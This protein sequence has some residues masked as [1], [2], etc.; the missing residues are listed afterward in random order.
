MYG[1]GIRYRA[2]GFKSEE[3]AK[4]FQKQRGGVIYS[5]EKNRN[6]HQDAAV[7]NSFDPRKFPYSVNWQELSEMAEMLHED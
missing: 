2:K 3:D 1:T 7:L 4:E 6:L 5:L